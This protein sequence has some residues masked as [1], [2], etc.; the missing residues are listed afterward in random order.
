MGI[1]KD[2][3]ISYI[4]NIH[5]FSFPHIPFF[6]GKCDKIVTCT[7]PRVRPPLNLKISDTQI[8]SLK[9]PGP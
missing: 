1:N 5:F 4:I 9:N 6:A 8:F 7:H 3:I 2:N